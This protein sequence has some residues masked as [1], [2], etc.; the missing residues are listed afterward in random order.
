VLC[1]ALVIS[2]LLGGLAA[3][4]KVEQGTTSATPV[5]EPRLVVDDAGAVSDS[6]PALSAQTEAGSPWASGAARFAGSLPGNFKRHLVSQFS[7]G[8]AFERGIENGNH[9]NTRSTNAQGVASLLYDLQRKHSEYT[10][11]YVASARHYLG[12]STFDTLSQEA[13]VAQLVRWTP[14]VATTLAY[15]FSMTPDFS[16]ELPQETIARELS[17]L[18]SEDVPPPLA[19]PAE[20]HLVTLRSTRMS[21]AV[22]ASLGYQAGRNVRLDFAASAHSRRYQDDSLFGGD[23]GT[24]ST[25][26][27]RTLGRRTAVGISYQGS[28]FHQPD[29]LDRTTVHNAS[30]S[31]TRV[32]TR[33]LQVTLGAGR[34]WS[35]SVGQAEVPLAPVLADLLGTSSLIRPG[36]RFFAAW[37]GSANLQS[38]WQWRKVNFGLGYDRSISNSNLLG[39]PAQAQNVTLTLGKLL[40]R[41]TTLSGSVSYGQNRFFNIVNYTRLDQG[42]LAVQLARPLFAGLDLSMFYNYSRLLKGVQRSAPFEHMRAGV[43][44]TVRLPRVRPS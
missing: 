31:L 14:H 16:G 36:S 13:G 11:E 42:V 19:V 37:T 4:Q 41:S 38:H 25:G 12:A 3:A 40:G 10:F 28:L 1:L 39:R 29:G 18:S 35:Y 2:C 15:R 32:L 26:L 7:I 23:S 20:G 30:L 33:H 5:G 22:H 21:H 9:V 8:Q 17:L 27:Q 24:V 44:L 6:S 43:M 34:L